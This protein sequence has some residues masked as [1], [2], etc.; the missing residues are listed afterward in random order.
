MYK[1][2]KVRGGSIV[3]LRNHTYGWLYCEFAIRLRGDIVQIL[4]AYSMLIKTPWGGYNKLRLNSMS[5]FTDN[6]E[7]LME[8]RKIVM[9]FFLC[10]LHSPINYN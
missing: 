5:L 9:A 1:F 4:L 7:K 10:R 6:T 3:C 8:F 2:R